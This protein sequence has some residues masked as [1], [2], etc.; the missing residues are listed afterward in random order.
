MIAGLPVG[1]WLL[2]VAA[3]VPAVVMA[4][5]AYRAHGRSAPA[6][7]DRSDSHTPDPKGDA[8]PHD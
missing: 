6:I 3:T 8:K 5:A 7:D 4:A 1:T 2:I